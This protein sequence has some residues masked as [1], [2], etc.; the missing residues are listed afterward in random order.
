[1]DN[2][3]SKPVEP[4]RIKGISCDVK[5]CMYHEGDNYCTAGKIAVGPT[6]ATSCTDTVCATFKQKNFGV[7]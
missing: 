3:N 7:Q 6:Y 5:S 1:M 4:K 2:F